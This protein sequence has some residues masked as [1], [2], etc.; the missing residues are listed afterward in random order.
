MYTADFSE[1]L[2]LGIQWKYEGISWVAPS[3]GTPVYRLSHPGVNDHVYTSDPNEI[4]TLCNNHGWYTD[5]SGRP[6]FYSGGNIKIYRLYDP[7]RGQHLL[8]IDENEY[9]TLP[10]YGFRQEGAVF[11][12]KYQGAMNN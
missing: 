6:S 11:R 7:S 4:S 5:F 3:I 8:T 9:N 1:V 2:K 10:Q 12:A